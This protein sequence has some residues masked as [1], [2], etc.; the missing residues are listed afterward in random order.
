MLGS[1]GSTAMPIASLGGESRDNVLLC[2]RT[3]SRTV[4]PPPTGTVAHLAALAV[5][6]RCLAAMRWSSSTLVF[7]G[8][9]MWCSFQTNDIGVP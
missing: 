4:G 7:L 1:V 5:S 8:H 2:T 9:E 6:R 3:T